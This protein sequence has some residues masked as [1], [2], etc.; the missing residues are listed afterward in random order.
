MWTKTFTDLP[1]QDHVVQWKCSNTV[2]IDSKFSAVMT[3]IPQSLL[4]K[5]NVEYLQW[6]LPHTIQP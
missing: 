6:T 3:Q 4:T 2:I 1:M 5:K